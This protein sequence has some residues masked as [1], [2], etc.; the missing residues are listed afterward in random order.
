MTCGNRFSTSLEKVQEWAGIGS[1]Q[2]PGRARSPARRRAEGVHRDRDQRVGVAFG[3]GTGVPE[4]ALVERRV[5]HLEH[6]VEIGVGGE[7]ARVLGTAQPLPSSP[8]RRPGQPVPVELGQVR[9]VGDLGVER[10]D[11]ASNAGSANSATVARMTRRRSASPV[12]GNAATSPDGPELDDQVA[13][14]REDRRAAAAFLGVTGG[15]RHRGL[16]RAGPGDHRGRARRRAPRPAPKAPWEHSSPRARAGSCTFPLDVADRAG[17]GV[18]VSNAGTMLYGMVEEAT[19]EQVRAHL[20]VNFPRRG[21]GRGRCSPPG[22]LPG[23]RLRDRPLH[24]R[25]DDLRVAAL[26]AAVP[27]RRPAALGA[28][29]GGGGAEPPGPGVTGASAGRDDEGL[30]F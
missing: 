25:H 10:P 22:H 18:V 6:Q 4:P 5:E 16:A 13:G 17:S 29:R 24:D 1:G 9:V 20:D 28:G 8:R 30:P 19:E 14:R 23:Q 27:A 3:Q 2:F 11:R 15:S 26:R 12:S 21:P 7:P